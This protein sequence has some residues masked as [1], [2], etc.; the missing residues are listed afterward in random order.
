MTTNSVILCTQSL[1]AVTTTTSGFR[2]L[3]QAV[4]YLNE[5]GK[6][7]DDDD[8][9]NFV[10]RVSCWVNGAACSL[11]LNDCK[12]VIKLCLLVI[13]SNLQLMTA[14]KQSNYEYYNV[15]ALYRR[16]QA[17]MESSEK[18]LGGRYT[19]QINIHVLISIFFFWFLNFVLF[20]REI[21]VFQKTLRQL[22]AESNERDAKLYTNMFT[23]M[24]KDCS[25]GTKKPKLENTDKDKKRW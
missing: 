21:K 23:R 9:K 2:I 13:K 14:R 25:I 16:A 3:H 4:D 20:Y 6:I 11:K 17:Y 15:K 22:Q 24:A 1:L 18:G 7:D 8:D 19:E 5:E 12:E 10:K